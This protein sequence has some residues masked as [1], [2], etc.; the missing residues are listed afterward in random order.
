[1]LYWEDHCSMN[2]RLTFSNIVCIVAVIVIPYL[3]NMTGCVH[4]IS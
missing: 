2:G 1:M 4:A 3:L